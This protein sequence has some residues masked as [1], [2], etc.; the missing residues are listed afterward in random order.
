MKD[1]P[2]APL[3]TR[4]KIDVW[5]ETHALIKRI[6]EQ[7]GKSIIECYHEAAQCLQAQGRKGR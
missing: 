4:L 1:E 5:T 2:K 7:T 6:S 3:L